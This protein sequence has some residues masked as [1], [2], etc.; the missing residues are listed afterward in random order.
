[1]TPLLLLS[2]RLCLESVLYGLNKE[3]GV[4]FKWALFYDV[5]ERDD[6]LTVMRIE[7]KSPWHKSRS[8]ALNKRVL[9]LFT[10]IDSCCFISRWCSLH[11]MLPVRMLV[12]WAILCTCEQLL[13]CSCVD[14]CQWGKESDRLLRYEM[15]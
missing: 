14:A 4:C 6:D 3:I 10:T 8:L 9:Q 2:L 13:S 1:M 15:T 5:V 12:V 11:T 7:L